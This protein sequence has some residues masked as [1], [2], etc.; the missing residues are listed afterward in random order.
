MR[1]KTIY[2][3]KGGSIIQIANSSDKEFAFF[4]PPPPPSSDSLSKSLISGTSSFYLSS[5]DRGK[6][7]SSHANTQLIVGTNTVAHLL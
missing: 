1:R 3:R 2:I 6:T 5:A 4:F 7:T